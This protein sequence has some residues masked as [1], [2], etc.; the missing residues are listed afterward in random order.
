MTTT[1]TDAS[2]NYAFVLPAGTF[3]LVA[4]DGQLRY[5]TAYSGGASNYESSSLFQVDWNSS[6]RVDFALSGGIRVSGSVVDSYLLGISGIQVDALDLNGNRVT[7]ANTSDGTFDLV[8]K[9]N[10]YKLLANDPLQRF[11]P[12][13]F[14]SSASL[15]AAT[16]VVVQSSGMTVPL[17]FILAHAGRRH[18]ASH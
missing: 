1:I 9:P 7:S 5:V 18:A 4:F 15:A 3:T 2:G 12:L 17:T 10:T 11:R 8:L 14:S 6:R 13:F 16:P